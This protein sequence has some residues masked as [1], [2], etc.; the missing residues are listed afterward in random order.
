MDLN[1]GKEICCPPALVGEGRRFPGV[2]ENVRQALQSPKRPALG[3]LRNNGRRC[4]YRFL[5]K[6]S[7]TF[8]GMGV[9]DGNERKRVSATAL[10]VS[11]EVPG[12]K[13]KEPGVLSKSGGSEDDRRRFE[14]IVPV[15]A[16]TLDCLPGRMNLLS[17]VYKQEQ[18]AFKA[19][20]KK[21][22]ICGRRHGICGE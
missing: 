13:G 18:G 11:S 5:D 9:R 2:T 7:E 15:H 3:F 1:A 20:A 4:V 22:A 19:V 10:G 16:K 17:L 14:D 6:E 21:V 12:E 8:D